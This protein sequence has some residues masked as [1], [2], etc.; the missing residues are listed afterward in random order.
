MRALRVFQI[1]KNDHGQAIMQA[2]SAIALVALLGL[3]VSQ[4][5]SKVNLTS[6]RAIF[7]NN[8][9]SATN[10]LR[11]LLSTRDLSK[12]Y[13]T[14]TD[15]RYEWPVGAILLPVPPA[16]K[17]EQMQIKIPFYGPTQYFPSASPDTD[18]RTSD[19]RLKIIKIEFEQTA[20]PEQSPS[21]PAPPT[22][23]IRKY[24][25]VIRVTYQSLLDPP[26]VAV[27]QL[28]KFTCDIS[29][30]APFPAPARGRLIECYSE[31]S[32][33]ETCEQ[34]GGRYV[35]AAT[36][37]CQFGLRDVT[38]GGPDAYI[39]TIDKYGNVSCS[40][41]KLTCEDKADY[42]PATL[43]GI[44]EVS[45]KPT[46]VCRPFYSS[47]TP[48]GP[49]L[50]YEWRIGPYT[51]CTSPCDSGSGPGTQTA[52]YRCMN[53]ASQL[54]VGDAN[55]NPP[56]PKPA[57]VTRACNTYSC[58][59][60]SDYYWTVG[61]YSCEAPLA[62]IPR[63]TSAPMTDATSPDMGGATFT[64]TDGVLTGPTGVTCAASPAYFKNGD[65][66]T[67]CP[68]GTTAHNNVLPNIDPFTAPSPDACWGGDGTRILQTSGGPCAP[69]AVAVEVCNMGANH[70]GRFMFDG[71]P[72]NWYDWSNFYADDLPGGAI[73]S[74]GGTP[75]KWE[76]RNCLTWMPGPKHWC[77]NPQF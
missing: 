17:L 51:L 62:T 61:S 43:V 29:V 52:A 56:T 15:G 12:Q 16:K 21:L 55:C 14:L 26:I 45:G 64:C 3:A 23:G 69:A 9:E 18:T 30:S 68:S 77:G 60:T 46:P 59:C 40:S 70:A 20:N 10:M 54:F 24:P 75:V 32:V 33:Q 31:T 63:N 28:G 42:W 35:P 2:M 34:M 22:N 5:M 7:T 41:A 19:L 27:R 49:V 74:I 38:C 1:L 65:N 47:T 66:C 73:C 50:P 48:S 76:I 53:T 39:S 37:D 67:Q 72:S 71:N 4:V 13:L 44:T 11:T 58:D 57:P 36:P 25:G 6:K 8:V